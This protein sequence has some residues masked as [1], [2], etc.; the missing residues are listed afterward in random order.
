MSVERPPEEGLL[1]ARDTRG[2][3]LQASGP[4]QHLALGTMGKEEAT[5]TD[6]CGPGPVLT[7]GLLYPHNTSLQMRTLRFRVENNP[8][9]VHGQEMAQKDLEGLSPKAVLFLFQHTIG[10][11]FFICSHLLTLEHLMGTNSG[12]QG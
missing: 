10:P 7:S 6:L 8:L 1:L 3:S 9:G 4:H 2:T 5:N 11:M 12:H